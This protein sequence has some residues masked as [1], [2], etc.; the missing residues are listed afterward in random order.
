MVSQYIEVCEVGMRIFIVKIDVTFIAHNLS[1]N[2]NF[3]FTFYKK[4]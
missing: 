4:D 1:V 3:L 2:N